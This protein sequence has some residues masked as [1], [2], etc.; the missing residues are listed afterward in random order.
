MRS[1]QI[2]IGAMKMIRGNVIASQEAE[3]A[4]DG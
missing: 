2:V 4:L 3:D 1:L